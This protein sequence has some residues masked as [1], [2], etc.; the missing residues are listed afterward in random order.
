MKDVGPGVCENCGRS[1]SDHNLTEARFCA[2]R[3]I[4]I[5]TNY[6]RLTGPKK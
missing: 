3:L 4:Y 5:E 2:E 1:T 6:C